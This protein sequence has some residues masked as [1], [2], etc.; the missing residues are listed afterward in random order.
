MNSIITKRVTV[1]Y[2]KPSFFPPLNPPLDK[3]NGEI[4]FSIEKSLIEAVYALIDKKG[5]RKELHKYISVD[6]NGINK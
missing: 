4:S 6:Y 5:I 2:N 3:I 1:F